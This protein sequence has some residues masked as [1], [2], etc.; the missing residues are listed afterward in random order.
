MPTVRPSIGGDDGWHIR[1]VT[2]ETVATDPEADQKIALTEI[3]VTVAAAQHRS[4]IW[5]SAASWKGCELQ[6]LRMATRLGQ[7]VV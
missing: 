3:T 7:P 6:T 4:K 2:V 5:A 1:I